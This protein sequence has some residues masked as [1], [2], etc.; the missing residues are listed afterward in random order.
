[1]RVV[2]QILLL[3]RVGHASGVSANNVEVGAGGHT[4]LSMPLDLSGASVHHGGGENRH[5]GVLGVQ[6]LLIHDGL[7]LADTPIQGHII[8][9]SPAT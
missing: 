8:I 5:D 6:D 3:V 4:S 9:L 7:M 2:V 1:M